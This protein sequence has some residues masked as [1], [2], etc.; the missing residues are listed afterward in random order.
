MTAAF[1]P[2]IVADLD[3]VVS[4][5]SS[6]Y[7][8][9][10]Y[11]GMISMESW[12]TVMHSEILTVLNRRDTRVIVAHEPG[13]T[14]EKGRPFLYGYIATRD[15]GDPYVYYVYVKS[16]YRRGKEKWGLAVGYGRALFSAAGIDPL[17]PFE[18]AC[19]T[20]YCRQLAS[21]IP[22]AEPNTLKARFT[23]EQR[24]REETGSGRMGAD[25][26]P[27]RRPYEVR[28]IHRRQ[29]AADR[30]PEREQRRDPGEDR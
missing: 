25:A 17:R 2:L 20:S 3:F 27:R 14:D 12:A 24:S 10:D 16:P 22:L 8:T 29:A 11:A 4:S 1:R 30:E 5:W 9:S 13:E 18:Y 21:K 28:T 15:G 19:P 6:S 26:R 7:R 23:H